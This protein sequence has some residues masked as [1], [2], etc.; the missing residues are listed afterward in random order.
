MGPRSQFS[1]TFKNPEYFFNYLIYC[2]NFNQIIFKAPFC[3]RAGSFFAKLKELLQRLALPKLKHK[4][5]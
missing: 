3:R 5:N 2:E 1:K 4:P